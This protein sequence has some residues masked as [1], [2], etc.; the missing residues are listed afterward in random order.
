MNADQLAQHFYDSS[1]A[2][3]ACHIDRQTFV[4]KLIDHR[5]TLQLLAVGAG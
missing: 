4:R 1:R 3:A 2:D 5:Q